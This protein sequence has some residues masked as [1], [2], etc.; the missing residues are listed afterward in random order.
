MLLKVIN[1]KAVGGPYNSFQ[2]SPQLLPLADRSLVKSSEA[3]I[4]SKITLYSFQTE[5]SIADWHYMIGQK[6]KSAKEIIELLMKNVSRN[7]TMLLNITQHGRGDLDTGVVRIC[8]DIGAWLIVNGE[9]VSGSRPFEVFGDNTVAY[10]RNQGHVSATLL[11]W[12]SKPVTL[13]ALHADGATL[14]KVCNVEILGSACSLKYTQDHN[15]LTISPERP[16]PKLSG[17]TDISLASMCHVLRI[18]HDKGR[19]ND[20]DP[21]VKASGWLRKYNLGIGDFNNDLTT[22][23]TPGEIWSCSF[24]G[25]NVA[26]VVPKEAGAGK[27]EIRIDGKKYATADL[28]ITGTCQTQQIVCQISDLALKKHFISIVNLGS[29]PVAVDALVIK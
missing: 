2:S 9:A 29:D 6:Y 1:L 11:N 17:I 8:K 13:S 5:T 10:T 14:G 20:D 21:G 18:T 15:G 16:L 4:E 24:T 3:I 22:S 23:D 26:V 12:D 19:F 7:G 28:S 27:I 25:T